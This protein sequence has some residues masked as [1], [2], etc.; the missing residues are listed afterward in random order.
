MPII[1]FAAA[2]P[3]CISTPRATPKIPAAHGRGR[4]ARRMDGTSTEQSTE[5]RWNNGTSTEHRRNFDGTSNNLR[6]RSAPNPERAGPQRHRKRPKATTTQTEKQIL[7]FRRRRNAPHL[8]SACT[9]PWPRA[10]AHR[11]KC[12]ASPRKLPRNP[13]VAGKQCALP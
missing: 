1:A 11:Y 8:P 12:T 2:F 5:H 6:M 3:L 9:L 10:G 4:G 13:P 7:R